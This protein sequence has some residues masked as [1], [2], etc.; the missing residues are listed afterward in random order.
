MSFPG[1]KQSLIYESTFD[2]HM[3][4]TMDRIE[5]TISRGDREIA[6]DVREFQHIL[7]RMVGL[8]RDRL[9]LEN[10]LFGNY[11]NFRNN[12][13]SQPGQPIVVRDMKDSA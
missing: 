10:V 4:R 8:E 5:E 6:L 7:G 9:R 11:R 1:D 12:F 3:R 2:E 13:N